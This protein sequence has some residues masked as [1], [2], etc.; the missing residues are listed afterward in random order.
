LKTAGYDHVGD[1]GIREREAFKSTMKPV[2]KHNLYVTRVGSIPYRN[3]V[4]LRKHLNENPG[5]LRRYNDLKLRLSRAAVDVNDYTYSKTDLILEFLGKEGV[6]A[7]EL[8]EIYLEN[9]PKQAYK[10]DRANP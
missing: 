3:H 2:H 6:S 10:T 9:S 5:D 7:E 1:L 4:F 8:E